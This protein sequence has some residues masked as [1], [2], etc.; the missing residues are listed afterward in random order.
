MMG[1]VFKLVQ[2]FYNI[3]YFRRIHVSE[4]FAASIIRETHHPDDGGS[5]DL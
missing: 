5:T 2:E 1:L 4:V 3:A